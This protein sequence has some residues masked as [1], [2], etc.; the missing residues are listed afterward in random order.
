[1]VQTAYKAV[2]TSEEYLTVAR[3]QQKAGGKSKAKKNIFF[4][5]PLG[6][7]CCYVMDAVVREAKNL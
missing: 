6:D 3:D 2:M 5:P 7:G 4:F 1:M